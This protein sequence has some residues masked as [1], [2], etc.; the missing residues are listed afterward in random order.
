MPS[1]KRA[2]PSSIS[3]YFHWVPIWIDQKVDYTDSKKRKERVLT[4]ELPHGITAF[5]QR[6]GIFAFEF[7]EKG[8]GFID[9]SEF[10]EDVTNPIH[11][12]AVLKKTRLLNVHLACLYAA[13]T[14]LNR[15]A[16]PKMLLTPQELLSSRSIEDGLTMSPMSSTAAQTHYINSG[17]F[18]NSELAWIHVKRH[19]IIPIEVVRL[20]FD[21]FSEILTNENEYLIDMVELILR[22]VKYYEDHDYNSSLIMYWAVIEKII[23]TIWNNF[24]ESQRNRPT[25]TNQKF[26]N[27]ARKEKLTGIDYTISNIIE[28]LSLL[29][30]VS[31]SLYRDLNIVRTARNKWIHDLKAVDQ[32]TCTTAYFTVTKLFKAMFNLDFQIAPISQMPF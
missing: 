23:N 3:G 30:L 26:I 25:G 28:Y 9:P 4:A 19:Q 2:L 31:F 18:A 17:S 6:E 12:E 16:L 1:E 5:V 21:I 13:L 27:R 32:E 7:S 24:L 29:N 14:K 11:I 20:S 10:L 22:G 15:M 8:W